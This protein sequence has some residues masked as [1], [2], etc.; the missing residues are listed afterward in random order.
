MNTI[1]NLDTITAL[2]ELDRECRAAIGSA[3]GTYREKELLEYCGINTSDLTRDERD[4]LLMFWVDTPPDTVIE[5]TSVDTR[6]RAGIALAFLTTYVDIATRHD[7][8]HLRQIIHDNFDS[9]SEGYY[10]Y[11]QSDIAPDDESLRTVVGAT[12]RLIEIG[13]T[14]RP[15]AL[16][17]AKL[18]HVLASANDTALR[19][20]YGPVEFADYVLFIGE[21]PA[22][23]IKFL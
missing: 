23:K 2:H 5:L 19:D 15:L 14:D 17:L 6:R 11:L 16:E 7:L 20:G 18:W 8:K 21:I 10:E 12:D 4:K 9:Y 22:E 3:I 1:S 13:V